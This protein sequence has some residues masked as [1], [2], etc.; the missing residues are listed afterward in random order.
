MATSVMMFFISS[1]EQSS[2]RAFHY[3]WWRG[4]HSQ[5][6]KDFMFKFIYVMGKA[7]TGELSC[8]VTGLVC[9]VL[10]CVQLLLKIILGYIPLSNLN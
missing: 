1:S 3:P 10:S 6:V 4:Q 2:G 7:L 8:P 9:L 5:H